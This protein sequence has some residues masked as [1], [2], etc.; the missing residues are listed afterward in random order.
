MIVKNVNLAMLRVQSR[1]GVAKGSGKE[2]KFNAGNFVD[3]EGQVFNFIIDEKV[4]LTKYKD[5]TNLT[6]QADIR[7]TA[8]GYNISGVVVKLS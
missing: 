1:E 8:R 2:Y 7:F 6:V 3:D 4:D 5:Q